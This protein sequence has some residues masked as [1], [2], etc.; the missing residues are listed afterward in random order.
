M[1]A[2][3]VYK[4]FFKCQ[5]CAGTGLYDRF[6]DGADHCEAC[7]G[8]GHKCRMHKTPTL[9]GSLIGFMMGCQDCWNRFSAGR[10]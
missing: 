2:P 9:F 7:H 8:Y 6:C 3:R 1:K 5:D 10:A 4:F